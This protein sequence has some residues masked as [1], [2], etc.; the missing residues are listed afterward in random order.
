MNPPILIL[1]AT[2]SNRDREAA[3][4]CELAGGA[5]E[6]VHVN[7]LAAG[8]RRL[9]DYRM[10]VLPGGFSYG[11]DL[12]AGKLWAVALR[13][14]LGD[15]LAAFVAAGRPVLGICNGFQALVKAGLLP[16]L[17][18]EKMTQQATLTRNDSARFE[19]RWVW[20]EPQTGSPCIFTQGLT[21]PIYCP[22][23]HGEGKFVARDET[24]LA[25]IEAQGLAA[26][27]YVG[28]PGT[29]A[30]AT[31]PSGAGYPWNPNGS[32][33]DIAGIC[34]PAGTVFGLMP[35]PEDHVIPQQH[36]QV[37]RG[38]RGLLGLPLFVNGVRYA[39]QVG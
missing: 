34:N 16:A 3:W 19:C 32:Q 29:A 14:R 33:N 4:A 7:Q 17:A 31:A 36:P 22:V 10:V 38:E 25:A 2:G 30:E 11:D 18:D 35:H 21:E 1:H 8:E 6:I 15:G 24:M 13:H 12:G 23:A 28:R 26:L 20:L 39:A 9:Q 37:H 27:R 5:P